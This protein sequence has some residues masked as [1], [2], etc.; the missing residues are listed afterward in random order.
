MPFRYRD[1]IAK[2]DVA[3]EASGT[4][5]GELF[6]AAAD[7]TMNIMVEDIATIEKKQELSVELENE[8]LDLLLFGFINELIFL[9]DTRHLLLRVEKISIRKTDTKY[10]LNATVYGEEPDPEKHSLCVDVK[11]T[12]LHQFS[13]KQTGEG[14]LATVVLDI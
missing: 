12:T 14:W 11:A 7:A 10:L 4:S 6:A 8:E 5:I 3:F 1:D 2:A 13:V 9:K